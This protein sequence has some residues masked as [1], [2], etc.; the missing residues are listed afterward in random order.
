MIQIAPGTVLIQNTWPIIVSATLQRGLELQYVADETRYTVFSIDAQVVF[1]TVIFKTTV[2]ASFL[3]NQTLNDLYK[4]DFETNFKVSANK[5]I[6]NAIT[7]TGSFPVLIQ[8][9]DQTFT[10]RIP[11]VHLSGTLAVGGLNASGTPATSVPLVVAGVDSGSIVRP[12]LVS[13]VNGAIV[14]TPYDGFKSTYSAA[15]IFTAAANPTDIFTISGVVNKTVRILRITFCGTQTT[16]AQRNV[17]IIKRSTVNT[18]GTSIVV[19]GVVHDTMSPPASAIVRAYTG[20]PTLGTSDGSIRARKVFVGTTA[21]NSDEVIFDFGNRPGQA[22]VLRGV[23]QVLAVN[24]NGV[25]STGN[26]FACSIEWTEEP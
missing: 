6:S 2:P 18:G 14:A 12:L 22:V 17:L 9:L 23:N 7:T 5:R 11:Q 24:L 8:G 19:A 25:S 26:S 15:S 4:S 13:P 20:N 10:P 16:S 1:K 3:T 21:S